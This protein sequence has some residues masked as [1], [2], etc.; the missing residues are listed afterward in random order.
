M[1][2]ASYLVVVT[3][4]GACPFLCEARA[5]CQTAR[6]R[7]IISTLN[8]HCGQSEINVHRQSVASVQ[9]GKRPDNKWSG[10]SRTYTFPIHLRPS[11]TAFN[12]VRLRRSQRFLAAALNRPC[13]RLFQASLALTA[14]NC[15]TLGSRYQSIMQRVQPSRIRFDSFHSY[16]LHIGVSQKWQR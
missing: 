14:T 15:S 11:Q 13:F 4:R 7:P 8:G 9:S 10:A 6:S 3:E 2:L 16:T 5:M 12:E 1:L